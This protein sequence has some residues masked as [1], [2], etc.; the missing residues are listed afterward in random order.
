MAIKGQ[1][2]KQLFKRTEVRSHPA[3]CGG[4]EDLSE[5]Q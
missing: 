4:K 5:K 3:S 2:F 1:K